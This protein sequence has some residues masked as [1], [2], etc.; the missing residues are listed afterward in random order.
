MHKGSRLAALL[1]MKA[2]EVTLVL[3]AAAGAAHAADFAPVGAKATLSVE[4]RFVAKG[5]DAPSRDKVYLVRE[6]NVTHSVDVVAVLLATKPQPLPGLHTMEAQQQA[7]LQQQQAQVQKHAAQ[8]A[9]MMAGVQ[10]IL[11]KC[12]EDEKCIERETMKMGAGL[13]G[14][15]QLDDTLKSGRETAAALKPGADRYQRWQGQSQQGRFELAQ[16]WHVLHR[17][18]I[19]MSLPKASCTH[20]LVRKGSGE[21]APSASPVQVEFDLQGGT[22]IVQLPVPM[23]LLA[24]TETHSTNE[25]AGTHSTPAPTAP[26]KGQMPLRLTADNKPVIA[27]LKVPLKGDWR[28]L[29]GEQVVSMGAGSWH[30]ASGEPGKLVLRWR[31]TAQ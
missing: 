9:P 11:A 26:Q 18:P 22:A 10:A 12:G 13:S 20:D 24:Y 6:W 21:F 14:T 2:L 25:P 1:V 4:Y 30:N 27:P 7:R 31:W 5:Q 3:A 8:M 17:D 23:G 19:C 28:S 15:Q 16:S 29:S